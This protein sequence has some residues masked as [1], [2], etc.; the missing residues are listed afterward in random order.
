[1]LRSTM[2]QEG[3]SGLAILA[4]ELEIVDKIDFENIIKEF[5]AA[6]SRKTPI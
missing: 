2:P 4:K 3:L 6:K 1:M 5:A